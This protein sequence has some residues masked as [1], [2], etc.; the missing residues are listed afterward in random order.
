MAHCKTRRNPFVAATGGGSSSSSMTTGIT[1]PT[2]HRRHHL[3]LLAVL[4]Y[5]L[6]AAT[7]ARAYAP[8]SNVS[9][10]RIP[11][12]GA[13]LDAVTGALLAP[14]L[15]P[16]VPGT[17]GSEK[18]QRHFADFFAH[19]LPLWTLEWHNSTATTPAT[20]HMLVPFANLVFRRDPPWVIA[21]AGAGAATAAPGDVARLTLAAHYDSL[22]R[23]EGFVGAVD[24]AAPCAMLLHVA[25]SIDAALTSKWDAMRAAGHAPDGLE[26]E[27]GVQILFLDGEE[28][29]V[30]WTDSDSLYG[31]RALAQTWET[32]EHEG[33]FSTPLQAISMFVLLDLLGAPGPRV[34]S[35]FA[36]THWAY[37]QLAAAEERLRKLG[38]LETE[39]SNN[40]PFLPEAR[41]RP[42]QFTRGFVQDD[43]VPFM[44]RGVDVLHIIPTPFPDV[45][46]TLDDDG[47]HL[48]P[49]TV[50]DW[51]TIMTA[52]VAEWME[53]DGFL[54]PVPLPEDTKKWAKTYTEKSEL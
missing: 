44:E 28:A 10:A 36:Q 18:A 41:K 38:A 6:L 3:L 16:R 54:P 4:V 46:H 14:I 40:H 47:A 8:L 12:G 42:E 50:R 32:T 30:S 15:I 5:Q 9:L 27:K 49:P 51:A 25:R 24:S 19:H 43:H 48:D 23:P 22:Y 11:S 53:L 52:F 33:I 26:E 1:R 17:A 39:A 31:S 2:K 20:G 21:E 7:T 34:P 37:Q 45:W 13:D 29:W 35:Y